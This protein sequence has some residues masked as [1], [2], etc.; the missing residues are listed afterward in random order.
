MAHWLLRGYDLILIG[1]FLQEHTQFIFF[2]YGCSG[3]S[4]RE[5]GGGV[6]GSN[7]HFTHFHCSVQGF[8]Q[9]LNILK[10]FNDMDEISADC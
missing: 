8:N 2:P 3:G 5:G 10:V 6:L 9:I 7:L 4:I 1:D